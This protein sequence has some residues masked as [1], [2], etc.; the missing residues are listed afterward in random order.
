[1]ALPLNYRLLGMVPYEDC[2]QD[3]RAFVARR[4]D[5]TC[6]EIWFVEHPPVF[7]QGMAGR[8]EHILGAGDIPVIQ[9]DRGGQV[10]Y[11]GPG[12]IVAYL[13][14]DLN[15][16][17]LGVRRLVELIEKS[18][19]GLLADYGITARGDRAAPGVYVEGAKVAALGLRVRKGC[20]Y[21]GLSL[22]VDMDLKP[23]K[24][25]NP[26]GHKGLRVTSMVTLG[27]TESID[28]IRA[29]L[30]YHLCTTLNYRC[31]PQNHA[32]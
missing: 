6:D 24:R 7:T 1:M 14:L 12:Q 8:P 10:T 19:I 23:F 9:T 30:Y 27:I 29:G 32:A 11:H 22:N 17:R 5:K 2:L 13:L 15:R 21:H 28:A 18:V 4:T 31:Y 25:I 26:C 20:S 16:R 3:M